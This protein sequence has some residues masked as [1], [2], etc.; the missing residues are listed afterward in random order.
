MNSYQVTCIRRSGSST[1]IRSVEFVIDADNMD[2]AE[3]IADVQ[4]VR[5]RSFFAPEL[6]IDSVSEVTSHV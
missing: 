6:D 2:Q 3:D 1:P 4:L 5:M